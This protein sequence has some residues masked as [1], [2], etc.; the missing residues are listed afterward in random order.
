MSAP[1]HLTVRVPI[2]SA[3]MQTLNT[4]PLQIIA[5]TPAQFLNVYN[6][7]L[8]YFHGTVPFN[9][10]SGDGFYF[11]TGT[12]GLPFI[13]YPGGEG[14]I[15]PSQPATGFVDQTQDMSL[16]FKDWMGGGSSQ[17]VSAASGSGLY[18]CQCNNNSG[19]GF[20]PDGTTDW[21]E[22]NGSLLAL[23]EYSLVS[24]S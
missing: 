10:V 15:G 13:A 19:D 9:A 24:A 17:P 23:V 3:Q 22:G 2:T 8:R 18:L 5:G 6:L 4:T 21:T 11:F 20:P 1:T 7:Y 16:W 12:T 14:F